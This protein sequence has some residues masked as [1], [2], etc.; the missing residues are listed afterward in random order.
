MLLKLTH[1]ATQLREALNSDKFLLNSEII[2]TVNPDD[3]KHNPGYA[4]DQEGGSI[5][6]M[7]QQ[8]QKGNHMAYFVKEDPDDI[9]NQQD[10]LWRERY[11][12]DYTPRS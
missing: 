9:H 1:N 6:Q 8:D 7:I 2:L 11:N 12:W 3:G 5:I 10:E 4:R